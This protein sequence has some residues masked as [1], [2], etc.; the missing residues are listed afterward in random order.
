MKLTPDE[1]KERLRAGG[2]PSIFEEQVLKYIE[3]LEQE[4]SD[5]E[6]R[7]EDLRLDLVIAESRI[8]DYD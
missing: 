2:N 5:L 1:I 3:Q 6:D 8:N 4:V 7:Y